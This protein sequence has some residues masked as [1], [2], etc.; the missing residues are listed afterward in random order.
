MGPDGRYDVPWAAIF[1]QS[2]RSVGNTRDFDR[3]FVNQ[4]TFDAKIRRSW[5]DTATL[6][7]RFAVNSKQR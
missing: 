7:H 5:I 2:A 4:R 1:V 6:G 3:E